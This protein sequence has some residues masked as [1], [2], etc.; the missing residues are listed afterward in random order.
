MNVTTWKG[1]WRDFAREVGFAGEPIKEALLS[2]PVATVVVTHKKHRIRYRTAL[3]N[4]GS[5]GKENYFAAQ[6]FVLPMAALRFEIAPGQGMFAGLFGWQRIEAR[7]QNFESKV[8][9]KTNQPVRL[10]S[11][12]SQANSLRSVILDQSMTA[13]LNDA[14]AEGTA[15]DTDGRLPLLLEIRSRDLMDSS[16]KLRAVH[17]AMKETIDLLVSQSLVSDQPSQRP[18]DERII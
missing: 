18:F 8:M 1:V 17:A 14:P 13:K 2:A 11:F 12:I 5:K 9:A 6:A 7:D 10:T 4:A 16:M 3:L 15:R